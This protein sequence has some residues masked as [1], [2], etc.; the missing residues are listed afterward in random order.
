M[1]MTHN[2]SKYDRVGT[3]QAS[4]LIRCMLFILHPTFVYIRPKMLFVKSVPFCFICMVVVGALV[5]LTVVLNF[6]QR[7]L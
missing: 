6:V 4:Y 5:V 7:S 3:M 2:Y 1:E